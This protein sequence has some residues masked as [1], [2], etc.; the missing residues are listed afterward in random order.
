MLLYAA[1]GEATCFVPRNLPNDVSAIAQPDYVGTGVM[2]H[3]MTSYIHLRD[4]R[5]HIRMCLR[6]RSLDVSGMLIRSIFLSISASVPSIV[7]MG[8][9]SR[10]TTH[11]SVRKFAPE[12]ITC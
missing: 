5:G 2:D 11:R 8:E 3:A 10:W 1:D 4:D 12:M 9:R 7:A 6:L